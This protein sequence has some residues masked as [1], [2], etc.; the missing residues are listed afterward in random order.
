LLRAFVFNIQ[1]FCIHDGE[2]IR[3]TFFFKG[4][5]LDCQWCHNPEGRDFR[6]QLMLQGD[7]CRGCG[8]CVAACPVDCIS[9]DDR[10]ATTDRSRCTA[11]GNCVESCPFMAREIAGHLYSVEE[12]VRIAARDRIFHETS[13]GGVTLSGGEAM[14]QDPDFLLELV[15]ELKRQGFHVAIDTCGDASYD[16]FSALLPYVDCFLYDIKMMDSE[17]HRLFTGNDNQRILTNLVRL[18]QA[19]APLHVRI[20]L[21]EGV[22]ASDA[23]ID[24][25]LA[26]LREEVVVQKIC[27]LPCHSMGWDKRRLL[28]QSG[29]AVG[30]TAP[31]AERM[32]AIADRFR[33]AGWTDVQI[34]G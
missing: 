22:N 24:G 20:P 8:A 33:K 30:F 3:T 7:R 13:G 21:I 28:G 16:A 4:C 17:L 25:I 27:L 9:M 26:F 18:S 32:D 19:G 6:P 1:R 29:P 5:S 31:D 15:R 2:G 34:G 14:L 23:A 12:L 10:T 11:C